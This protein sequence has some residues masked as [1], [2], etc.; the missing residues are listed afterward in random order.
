MYARLDQ[1]GQLEPAPEIVNEAVQMLQD[2]QTVL[3]SVS[4]GRVSAAC[5]SHGSSSPSLRHP[6]ARLEQQPFYPG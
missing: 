6:L 3:D 4:N 2:V 5:A 1:A